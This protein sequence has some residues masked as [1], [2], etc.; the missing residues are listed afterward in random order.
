MFHLNH[1]FQLIHPG[2][3]EFTLLSTKGSALGAFGAAARSQES[4]YNFIGCGYL[5][6]ALLLTMK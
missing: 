4:Y 1:F 6:K 2:K 3:G 5:K